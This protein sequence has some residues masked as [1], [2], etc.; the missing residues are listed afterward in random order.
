MEKSAGLCIVELNELSHVNIRPSSASDSKITL[1]E[2]E[3]EMV[4]GDDPEHKLRQ[5]GSSRR[6][7]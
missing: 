3:K 5:F 2:S 1:S 6:G 4:V 7:F